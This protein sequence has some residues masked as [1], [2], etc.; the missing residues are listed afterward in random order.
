MVETRQRSTEDLLGQ[1]TLLLS[2]I[3]DPELPE[4]TI[5]ELGI[6]R[7]VELDET[8]G[9]TVTITP[10]YSGCPAMDAIVSEIERA[11]AGF[12]GPGDEAIQVTVRRVLAPAWTTDWI[13]PTARAKLAR[14]GIAPPCSVLAATAGGPEGPDSPCSRAAV[15][16]DR[17][18]PAG[19][20]VPVTLRTRPSCPRCGSGATTLRSAFG[21]T[22]C[23]SSYVCD[24]CKE[25]FEHLKSH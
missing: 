13:G 8:T 3:P 14:A 5:A 2:Q 12:G 21:S 15:G 1:L 17:L 20:G 25:P 24:S 19:R 22:A 4:L 10:T 7:G 23:R 6:L 11:L 18:A 9:V 16:A